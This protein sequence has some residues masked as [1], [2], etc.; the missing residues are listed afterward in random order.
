MRIVL[1]MPVDI[2]S[3]RDIIPDGEKMPHGY[4]WQ[5]GGLLARCLRNTGCEVHIVTSSCHVSSTEVWRTNNLAI[6]ITPR[7]KKY[8]FTLDAYRI[9]VREMRRAINLANPD[10]VHAHW[11]YEF[12]LAG[13]GSEYPCL[14]TARDDPWVILLMTMSL[15]RLFRYCF[16]RYVIPRIKYLSFASPYMEECYRSRYDLNAKKTFLIP[17]ALPESIFSQKPKTSDSAHSLTFAVTGDTGRLKNVAPIIRAFSRIKDTVPDCK[18][19][20]MGQGLDEDCKLAHMASQLDVKKNMRFLGRVTHKN[21]LR[22]LE[23]EADILIHPSL[24]ESFGMT[25]LEAMAKGLPVIGGSE[26]GAVP[27]LLDYG[28]AGKL[29]DVT[30]P[31]RIG[32]AMH[33]MLTDEDIRKQLSERAW[34]RAHE[35]F[36][37]NAISK[38]YIETYEQILRFS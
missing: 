34:K 5:M 11:T 29:A 18:F 25:V 8:L 3:L 30:S 6:W 32:E 33:E 13:L 12:A 20:F 28:K 7:R 31:L 1:C 27:W 26:S 24:E 22:I 4:N 16:A 38:I 19:I 15:Y 2:D 14:I 23:K 35:E 21:L 36:N 9:E 37:F 10:I 17:N